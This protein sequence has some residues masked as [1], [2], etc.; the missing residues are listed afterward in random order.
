[1][2][3]AYGVPRLWC[4]I[5]TQGKKG[6]RLI[7]EKKEPEDWDLGPLQERLRMPHSAPGGGWRSLAELLRSLRTRTSY[8]SVKAKFARSL[9][10]FQQRLQFRVRWFLSLR[11]VPNEDLGSLDT[12]LVA[13]RL[14]DPVGELRR[15][16]Q[17]A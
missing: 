5:K 6:E 11:S 14:A 7:A 2:F 17:D 9:P 16:S 15:V 4:C 12:L 8:N 10:F 1:M 3:H 13:Y